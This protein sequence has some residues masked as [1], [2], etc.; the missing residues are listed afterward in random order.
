MDILDIANPFGA[1]VFHEETVSSTMDLSRKLEAEGKPSGTVIAADFQEAGRGRIRRRSW[2]MERGKN[3]AFTILLRYPGV[4][5][6]PR[7]LT[8]RTGLAVCLAIEDFIPALKNRTLIKWPNDVMIRAAAGSASGQRG[9]ITAKKAAGILTEA[10]G[11]SV[12]IGIGI[13]VGQGEFPAGLEDKAISL[14]QAAGTDILPI[15]RFVLLE[16]IL[17]GLYTELGATGNVQAA[18]VQGGWQ[19]RM[20][21]RLYMKGQDVVFIEGEV[22]SGKEIRGRLSGIGENGELLI[23]PDTEVQPRPFTNGELLYR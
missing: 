15:G 16:K 7:A 20:E 6:I 1:P 21:T 4:Q 10:D 2:N 9:E 12:H 22:N 5:A 18:E 13:N 14:S 3:L 19:S 23:L 17:A 8:L 11:E